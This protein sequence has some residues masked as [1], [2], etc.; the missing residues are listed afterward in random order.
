MPRETALLAAAMGRHAEQVFVYCYTADRS[1]VGEHKQGPVKVRA[2]FVPSWCLG[3]NCFYVP[4]ELRRL[5]Q[6]N[7]DHLDCVLITASFLPENAPVARLLRKAGI[8]YFVSVGE[9]FNPFMFDGI[10]GLKKALYGRLLE[11]P[12]LRNAAGIRLYSSIQQQHVEQRISLSSPKFFIIK[13]GIDSEEIRYPTVAEPN[14]K[15]PEPVFGFLG[16]LEVRKKGLDL[17]LGGWSIYRRRGGRGSLLIA[18][19]ALPGEQQKLDRQCRE[20]RITDIAFPG[21][22]YG[23]EKVAFLRKLTALVHPSR[24]EGIPRV[25]REALA[26]RCPVVVTANTNLHDIVSQYG[27]GSVV[28]TTPESV[29]DGLSSME[30]AFFSSQLLRM[31]NAAAES[32]CEFD[33]DRISRQYLDCLSGNLASDQRVGAS[34]DQ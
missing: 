10:R 6:S 1:R 34:S 17:L 22:Q 16:R 20:L 3:R 25:I 29:A 4:S 32:T 27:C 19:P 30:Q 26:L 9:G 11:G 21:P 5:I 15:Q 8:P 13:E 28:D 31:R 33:W 12:I 18:G 2:F 23:P 14:G 7:S 24:H